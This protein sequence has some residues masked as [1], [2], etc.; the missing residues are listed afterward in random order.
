MEGKTVLSKL[1]FSVVVSLF[2]ISANVKS[3]TQGRTAGDLAFADFQFLASR[4]TARP[5]RCTPKT[6][7]TELAG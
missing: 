7:A 3:N 6:T 1:I 5:E 2:T 4:K